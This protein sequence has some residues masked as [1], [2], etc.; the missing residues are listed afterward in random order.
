MVTLLL[1]QLNQN[2]D[3]SECF[4]F[5]LLMFEYSFIEQDQFMREYKKLA[6]VHYL[7]GLV[8]CY[9]SRYLTTKK[10][11]TWLIKKCIVL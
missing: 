10:K 8:K 9:G 11:I 2:D 6:P 4:M 3:L 5:I 7:Y 1:L